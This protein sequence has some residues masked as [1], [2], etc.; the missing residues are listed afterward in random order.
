MEFGCV[1][2]HEKIL[3]TYSK[4]NQKD[5]ILSGY[6]LSPITREK[7]VEVCIFGEISAV[8]FMWEEL[9]FDDLGNSFSIL[10]FQWDCIPYSS[11]IHSS[12]VRTFFEKSIDFI[13]TG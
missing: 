5:G 3:E 8:E 6:S 12:I 13:P 1:F 11:H 9:L 4:Q 7:W 10:L 2:F